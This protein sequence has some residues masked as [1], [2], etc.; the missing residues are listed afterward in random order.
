MQSPFRHLQT[1]A[2]IIAKIF[3]DAKLVCDEDE[4]VKA[5]NPGLVDVTYA[6][7]SGARFVDICKLTDIF[8]GSIIRVIRRLEELLRQLATAATAIGMYVYI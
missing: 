7:A 5:F 8:E 2:R 4:Y 6:W 3:I 1:T